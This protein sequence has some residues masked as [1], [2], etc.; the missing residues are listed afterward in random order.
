MSK[1]RTV[2]TPKVGR[3]LEDAQ[4]L[5]ELGTV[6]QSGWRSFGVDVLKNLCETK[7]LA[8]TSSGRRS[9]DPIKADYEKALL[10]YVSFPC[11]SRGCNMTL[12]ISRTIQIGGM[13]QRI[14]N[15]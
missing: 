14:W 13:H 11:I 12:T 15:R 4:R 9:N 7:A 2:R 8:V 3:T 5:L 10:A 1:A 6:K